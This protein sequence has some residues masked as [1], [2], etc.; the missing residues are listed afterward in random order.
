MC[1]IIGIASK[2]KKLDRNMLTVGRDTMIHR[3]PDDDG[4]WWA[5]D[6]CVGLGHR[7]L[8]IIDLS[9]AG[10]QPMQETKNDFTIV[11]NGEIYNHLDLKQ[12][13]IDKGHTFFS[14]SDTEVILAA[15]SEWG[16]DCLS[17][18]NGMFAFAIYNS[19]Q[20][21]IFLARD[22]AGEK[23]LFYSLSDGIFRFASELKGL[24]VDPNFSHQINHQALDV[25]LTVGYVPG[26]LCIVQGANKLPAAHAMI[27]DL[28]KQSLRTWKYWQLPASSTLTKI[29]KSYEEDLLKDFEP[30][31]E[32]AVHKQLS[33]DVPVGIL[34]SGGVDS[35]LITAMAVR[36]SSQVKTFTVG[37]NGYNKYDES[38][39][40]RLIANYFGTEHIELNAGDTSPE[41]LKSLARQYDEPMAD[42]SM[43]STYLVSHL[44]R[45][46]CT[47]A[48]GGDGGDELF[49]GYQHYDRLLWRQQK[50]DWIPLIAR[51][52]MARCAETLL[53]IG[54]KGRN[55]LQSL[56][57][58]LN[59]GLPL[60][61]SFF[62]SQTRRKLMG[63]RIWPLVGECTW[64]A[65][66]PKDDDLLQR[67]TRMDFKNYMTEDILVKIDRASMLNSLELR[68]PFLDY[69][70]IEFAFGRVPSNMKTTLTDR[71]IFLKKLAAKLLPSS[72]DMERKQGFSVPLGEWLKK[73]PWRE[74]F[75]EVLLDNQ[76][77]FDK[78]IVKKLLHG[79][80]RGRRNSERLL[81]LVLFELWRREYK[82]TL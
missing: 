70:V 10:H 21:F 63:N 19:R 43:I 3:G 6:G 16:K 32:D 72:F 54:F 65:A 41:L 67:L 15:Y 23:P 75:C 73:G 4:A 57:C 68:A 11:F 40:A 12:E 30:L 51:K 62:D 22:R 80:D 28:N 78:K 53:P 34:L 66:A 44:V 50:V 1:A 20:R 17:R 31:L 35:S 64:R 60:I 48:L 82:M 81:C 49:G 79:Q 39:H 38:D 33:A 7:R 52:M 55:W 14:N 8:A 37:F 27:F 42:S 71:K 25:Y 47:V 29:T 45:K 61:A 36:S 58:D 56:N 76:S 77:I 59:N 69:R 24:L 74:L 13:L 46:H 18:L 2:D 9:K 5:K 26:D